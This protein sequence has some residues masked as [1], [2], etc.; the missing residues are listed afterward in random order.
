MEKSDVDYLLSLSQEELAFVIEKL[1]L[2]QARELVNYIDALSAQTEVMEE[3]ATRAP[4]K[5][6]RVRIKRNGR[7]DKTGNVQARREPINL[8]KQRPNRFLSMPEA[9]LPNPLK[10]VDQANWKGKEP[11]PRMRDSIEI[12]IECAVCDELFIISEDEVPPVGS[13]WKCND[14]IREKVDYRGKDTP[15]D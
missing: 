11:T 8:E 1:P 10:K 14:C 2:A 13:I 7:S 4:T 6:K 9:K 3:K 15:E 5:P 12:E